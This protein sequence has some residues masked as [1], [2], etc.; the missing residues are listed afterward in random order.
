[1]HLRRS[2]NIDYGLSILVDIIGYFVSSVPNPCKSAMDTSYD[3]MTK[4]MGDVCLTNGIP[5]L[6]MIIRD[7]KNQRPVPA[8]TFLVYPILC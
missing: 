3:R 7:E 1:M 8:L 2:F 5:T 4:C 6:Q